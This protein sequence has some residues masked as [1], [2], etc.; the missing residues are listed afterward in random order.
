V[1]DPST[2]FVPPSLV[3]ITLDGRY[4][5]TRHL[6]D[7]GMGTVFCAEH[8]YMKKVVALKV[9][10]PDLSGLPKIAER[11]RREAEIAAALEHENIVR[12]TDFGRSQEGF[13]FLA[14]ELLEGESLFE[15]LRAGPL[16]PEAALDILIQICRG[17][18]AAHRHGVVHRDLKPENIFLTANPPD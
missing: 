4:R 11:F 9:L 15:R 18:E 2:G 7:G 16:S 13:L 6:A 12:V 5:L 17:L 1:N 10:R 8:V 14:M 3:G